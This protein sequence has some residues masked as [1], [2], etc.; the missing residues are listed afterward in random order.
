[1]KKAEHDE[2][3]KQK[4][5]RLESERRRPS[6]QHSKKLKKRGIAIYLEET[7]PGGLSP[8]DEAIR[9]GK[10]KQQKENGLK[11]GLEN[12]GSPKLRPTTTGWKREARSSGGE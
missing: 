6:S 4:K 7:K 8:Q 2:R 9:P 12:A 1:M 3:R 5:S 10:G 11:K